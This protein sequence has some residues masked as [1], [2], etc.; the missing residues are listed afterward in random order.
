M[1]CVH[2]G[3]S[4]ADT[5]TACCNCGKAVSP[6][7][8]LPPEERESFKGITIDQDTGE[9]SDNNARQQ[10]QRVYYR[11]VNIGGNSKFPGLLTLLGIGFL[12]AVILFFAVPAIILMAV[13]AIV[14]WFLRRLFL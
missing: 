2:C 14:L 13:T 10:Q 12:V 9:R 11:Y 3:F 8:V 7:S 1:R 4:L 6:V 5:D